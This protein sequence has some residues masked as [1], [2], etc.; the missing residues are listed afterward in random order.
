MKKQALAVLCIFVA[1]TVI[2]YV[3]HGM[4][5][6]EDY[7]A[8][9]NLWRPMLEMNI[10]L[11]YAVTLVGSLVFVLI[12]DRFFAEKNKATALQYGFLF[13]LTAGMSMGFGSYAVM[14]IPFTMA[15][16]WFLGTLIASTIGGMFLALVIGEEERV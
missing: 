15:L 16:V 11:S 4:L 1:W 2:D 5:L 13:G 7:Q 14:P 10:G 8:T 6:F 3:M 12:Y 9:A